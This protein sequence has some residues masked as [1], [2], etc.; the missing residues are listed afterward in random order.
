MT[1]SNT[2]KP[3][4]E[5]IPWSGLSEKMKAFCREY[6]ATGE[7]RESYLRVYNS[8]N[9]NVANVESYRMLKREDIQAY[10]AHLNKPKEQKAIN[11]KEKKREVLWEIINNPNSTNGDK[12]RAMEVLCK[13]DGDFVNISKQIVEQENKLEDLSVEELK[14]L[15]Q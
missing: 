7:A 5:S 8:T 14:K 12:C 13:I 11:E 6:V 1:R 9:K 10:I 2:S 4:V 3:R 15:V